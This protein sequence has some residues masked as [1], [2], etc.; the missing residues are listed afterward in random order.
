ML[1][2]ASLMSFRRFISLQRM[3]AGGEIKTDLFSE[4][5]GCI[6][7][8][9][10]LAGFL[11]LSRLIASHQREI[12]DRKRGEE[13]LRET[14]AKLQAL[15]QAMPD[16]VFF[17]DTSGRYMMVNRAFEEL[18]G[19]DGKMFI[20][21]TEGDFMPP[22]L[23]ESCR[24]SDEALMKSG[25]PLSVEDT[26][27]GRGGDKRFID[28][29]KAPIYDSHGDL[30][31]LLGVSRDVTER[32][33]KDG[34][35]RESEERFRGA[36]E[37]A[38]VGAS[39]VDQRGRFIKVNRKLCEMLGYSA[40][41][42]LSKTFSDV[43]HPEDIQI[44]TDALEKQM[45]GKADTMSIEKRYI[46]KDGQVIHV[47]VSPSVIR[48]RD[49]K[50]AYCLGLFQDITER[51][52]AEDIIARLH[53]KNELILNSAGEGIYGLDMDGNVTFV[54]PAAA[55]MV[56]WEANELIG[57]HQH[58][59][60]HH[61]RPD[62]TPYPKEDCKIYAAF[63]DGKV[64]HVT[65]EVFWRKDGT[66]FPVDY[67]STPLREDGKIVGAVVVFTDIT[68]RRE[69]EEALRASEERLSRAQ[70]MAHV[71]NWE[72]NLV[73]D[74]LYW[75]EEVYRI[76]GVD[77]AQFTPTFEAVGKAMHPDD[78]EPFIKTVNAAINERKP[79]EMDYRLVR[80][81][82]AI[83]TV[84]TI[85]EVTYDPAGKPLSHLGTVQD[86]TEQKRAEE[87]L[88]LFRNLLNHT[89]DAIFVNDPVTGRFLMVNNRACSNLGYGSDTLLLMST[90][91]IEALFPDQASWDAHV[92]EVRSKGSMILEG[93]HKRN[94]GTAY[95][96]EVNVTYMTAG[97]KDYM[98]AVARDITD[99]KMSEQALRLSEERLSRAQKMAHVGNWSWNIVTNELYWSEEVY[100]IYGL[101]PAQF[102]PTFE[103]VGKAMHPDDLEPFINA[104]NAAIYERKPFEMDYRLIRPDGTI[105][106]VH[107]IGEVTYDPAGKPLVKSGTIQDITERR[108]AEEALRERDELMRQAVR[109]S[110]FGIFDHNQRTDT[111]YWSPQQR[112]IHG[113]GP[114]EPITLQ[115]FLDLIHPEDREYIEA[116]VQRAHDPAGDG[117]WDVEHRIIRRDGTVR[118]LKARSQTFF[119]GE[120][121]A[122]RPV[123]TIGAVLDITERKRNEEELAYRNIVLVTQ[124]ETSIDGILVVD[125][126]GAIVS[127]NTRFAEMWGFPLEVVESRS[128]LEPLQSALTKVA[129]PEYFLRRVNYLYEHREEKSRDE[130]LLLDGRTF[131]RYSAPMFGLDGKYFGRVWYFRDI[132]ERKQAEEALNAAVL[133]AIEEKS[134]SEAIISAIG[135]SLVI[136]DPDFR[137]IYQNRVD[138]ELIG[139]HRGEVCFKAYEGKEA[140][141][142]GCPA[143]QSFKDGRIH[144]GERIAITSVG[145][146][147]L[148]ITAS[149]LLDASGKVTAVIEMVKDITERKRAEALVRESQ[150]K[151]KNLVELSAD[152]IYLS[153]KDGNQV[154]MNDQAFKVLEYSP[155]DVIGRPWSFLIHPDDRGTSAA[156]F[157]AM[158]EQQVDIFNFENRYVTKSG[159]VINVL[160]NVRILRNEQGEIVGT[161]GIARDITQRKQVEDRLK[162]FSRAMEEAT[163]GVQ[164]VNLDG[165]I[166]YSNRAA[167]EMHG[168]AAGELTGKHVNDMG[169]ER[170]FS[171][172]VIIPEIMQTGCWSGELMNVRKDG[173]QFP[174]WLSTALVKNDKGEHI[175]MIGIIRDITE[176][177]RAE[178]ALRRSHVELEVLV[179]ERTAEL[180]MI[181][182]Q[183]SMFSS[184]LQEAR[185]KE[186][187]AIAREIH[188]ELGQALTALKID[189]SWLKK[190]LP[191][192]QKTLLEKQASMSELVEA[193]IQTVK[194]ISTELRPGIL[195]HLGL[196]AAIEWQAEE[197]Q[198]RTG[199]PCGVSIMHEEIV[200]DKDRSTTIFRI[201]QETLTNITRH[202][203]ATKVSVRLEKENNSLILEVSDNG[204]GITEKQL[205]DSKSLGLMGMRE[206]AAY[207]G[208]HVNMKGVR[209]G[210]TTVI[211][212]IPL[213]Q[214]GGAA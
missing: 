194:K 126:N 207:W 165:R 5:V 139:D 105:R 99:R 76:Y 124:Q 202:A 114:D 39:M 140:I 111:I 156:V 153:D 27:T 203:K 178:V 97:E 29:V 117:I 150:E 69:S 15:I 166:V 88:L 20:G 212:H 65:D 54:N 53:R 214:T 110:Q 10:L 189:L 35:M 154:F 115:M 197:F 84:H 185:E 94:D 77:P 51:K 121:G 120:G 113:W 37:N 146:M 41:E 86:I 104:V 169:M 147:Y 34:A 158:I 87:S 30:L 170:E 187:T 183:L 127:Y 17:K 26:M 25:R 181:N 141:C 47:N 58:D 80:P 68:D 32:R 4:I 36:F 109:V 3:I 160:H 57:R 75:S 159:K 148:D 192:N 193:T 89:E 172:R 118:W 122:R 6:V 176:R 128:H 83:R 82:G 22:D 95:P 209:N 125:E 177:R 182:E 98:V 123:R 50:P 186:R 100:Y 161:Q 73:T 199:I 28:S 108:Q 11:Y 157:T 213:E 23:A 42:L 142:E 144:R 38:A 1:L 43:T 138:R 74:H 96:V 129:D 133:K 45:A 132:T 71:G 119:E 44:G 72:N 201:F 130:F 24:K 195:D 208:G 64:H 78:L 70:K 31:G 103:A 145:T 190:R 93:V 102:T 14:N 206:R 198:K 174:I 136:I 210:G 62:G 9:I 179:H 18:L 91:D 188:D 151:Y 211:V 173:S 21:K 81:D 134:K 16:A 171:S 163:D 85:G 204:K 152:I 19:A 135:D 167:E 149:P 12:N 164:I 180:R 205:S 162:L 2:A 116:S 66:S 67:V 61:S 200:P 8:F 56:G 48:D 63:Q 79:F 90:L 13:A 7:S 191:K 175:A 101:D 155:E 46:R 137:I 143:V 106:T 59:I 112:L 196:T 40:E 33:L 49:G 60:L 55:Q 131:D 52:R 184:Y 92:N 107:T 168:Y